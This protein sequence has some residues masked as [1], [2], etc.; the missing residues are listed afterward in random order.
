[1]RKFFLLALLTGFC[2]FAKA[3]RLSQKLQNATWVKIMSDETTYNFL[4]AEKEFQVFFAA[5]QKERKKEITRKERNRSSAEEQ[6]R[7][8]VTELLVSEYLQWSTAI[9]PFVNADGSIKPV[10]ERLAIISKARK[11]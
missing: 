4:D 7:E 3:Q 5:F 8:T 6:H 2:F 10:A 9:R 1:M 11:G